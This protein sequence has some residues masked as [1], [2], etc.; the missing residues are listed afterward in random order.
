MEK[1]ILPL[2]VIS[3]GLF[4]CLEDGLSVTFEMGGL[5][6]EYT[7]KAADVQVGKFNLISDDISTNAPELKQYN[8]ELN[9]IE[10]AKLKTLVISITA[11]ETANFS[12]ANSASLYIQGANLGE[13]KIASKLAIDKSAM[14]IECDVED[15]DV[16]EHIKSGMFKLRTEFD[17]DEVPATD[18]DLKVEMTYDVT[19]NA[20]Q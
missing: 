13:E 6:A 9:K 7:L 11:P 15:V 4:S 3:L 18:I 17:I 12:F 14:T 5:E 19:A 2:L 16:V 20:L 10:S 1:L 8:T